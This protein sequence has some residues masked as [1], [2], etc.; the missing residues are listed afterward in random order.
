[1]RLDSKVCPSSSKWT[2]TV[3]ANAALQLPSFH[4][5][6]IRC[7]KVQLNIC[8]VPVSATEDDCRVECPD[9]ECLVLDRDPRR[10]PQCPPRRDQR[11][12][13]S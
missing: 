6:L 8:E 5:L 4:V 3:S 7:P 2:A 12:V 1:M 10:R 13:A 11:E 9:R